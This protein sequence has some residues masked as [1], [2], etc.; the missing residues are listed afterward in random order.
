MGDE[1]DGEQAGNRLTNGVSDCT[2]TSCMGRPPKPKHLR[3][4][5]RFFLR[6][7]PGEMADLEQASRNLEEPVAAI[8]RKGA[9]LYVQSR[10]K[11]GSQ[12]K[13]EKTQ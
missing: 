6:L 7:T 5:E 11:G 8:L 10:G 2:N 9:L 4:S 3:R 13:G 1:M 12:M